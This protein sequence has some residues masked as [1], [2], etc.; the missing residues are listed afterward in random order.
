MQVDHAADDACLAFIR[1]H[2]GNEMRLAPQQQRENKCALCKKTCGGYFSLTHCLKD[3]KKRKYKKE[4]NLPFCGLECM[5]Q[6][7]TKRTVKNWKS[8][9]Q[10]GGPVDIIPSREDDG[11]TSD[12][13]NSIT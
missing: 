2:F 12:E 13:G 3:C 4:M 5:I 10:E 7:Q 9:I 11:D 1:N 6:W 8:M